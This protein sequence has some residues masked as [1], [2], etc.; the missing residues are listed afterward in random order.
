MAS[1]TGCMAFGG[2]VCFLF[3]IAIMEMNVVSWVCI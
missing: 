2:K 1:L 3:S